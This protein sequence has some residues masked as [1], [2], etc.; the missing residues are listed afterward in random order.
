LGVIRYVERNLVQARMVDHAWDWPWCSATAHVN[1]G[2]GDRLLEKS[3]TT[4]AYKGGKSTG[5]RGRTFRPTH[6]KAQSFGRGF[7]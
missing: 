5:E 1:R 6:K 3:G 2:I 7:S 4:T